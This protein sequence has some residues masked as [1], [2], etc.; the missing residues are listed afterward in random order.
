MLEKV[1]NTKLLF[2]PFNWIIVILMLI[3]AG[4]FGNFGLKLLGVQP[5]TADSK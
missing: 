4:A 1:I 5:A 2:N 3:I